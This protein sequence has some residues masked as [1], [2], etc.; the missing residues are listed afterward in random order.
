MPNSAIVKTKLVRS[1]R[2]A[3]PV[4][5]LAVAGFL[6]WSIG[7]GEVYKTLKVDD[8][9]YH[10]ELA[11]TPKERQQGL[12][13]RESLDQ[14]RGMLFTYGQEGRPCF[15]MKDMNFSLDIIWVDAQKTVVY[16]EEDVAPETHPE[17]FCPSA[18]A[19]YVIEL[20]AG[21]VARIGIEVGDTLDF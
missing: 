12:S 11:S 6:L 2:L 9:K 1:L 21:E 16:I 14:D 17:S 20:N 18:D 3:V 15:W 8:H 7:S 13:G 5:V 10:L 4:L 19:L